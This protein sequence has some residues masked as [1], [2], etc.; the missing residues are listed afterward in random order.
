MASLSKNLQKMATASRT[1]EQ[2]SGRGGYLEQLQKKYTR[3]EDFQTVAKLLHR[4]ATG[5]IK[6]AVKAALMASLAASGLK[7]GTGELKAAVQAALINATPSGIG[8]S[9]PT[10]KSKS[11]YAKAGALEYGAVRGHKGS[12]RGRQKL[13]K[14]M[15]I[16]GYK[17]SGMAYIPPHEFFRLSPD[18]LK[19]IE[20]LYRQAYQEAFERYMTNR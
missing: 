9:M 7:V 5:K 18:Q 11:F 2:V 3:L 20:D 8:I 4:N 1:L 17:N 10:G 15:S 13:K 14:A 16:G 6:V 12:K 19:K